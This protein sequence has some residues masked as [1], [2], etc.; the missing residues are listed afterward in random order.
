M[1]G[2]SSTLHSSMQFIILSWF[3][4]QFDFQLEVNFW[5]KSGSIYME[6]CILYEWPSRN[7]VTTWSHVFNLT[8]WRDSCLDPSKPLNTSVNLYAI[9]DF[10]ASIPD[11]SIWRY[12]TER[13]TAASEPIS[14][15]PS[16]LW[17]SNSRGEHTVA[18]MTQ[19]TQRT[20]L[21]S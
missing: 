5:V 2:S 13:C 20:L 19:R 11:G 9:D 15:A 6:L 1:C 16:N 14:N 17:V 21:S 12:L 10:L 8:N 7:Q 3:T 4:Q 18:W